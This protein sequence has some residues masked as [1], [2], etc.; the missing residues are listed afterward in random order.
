MKKSLLLIYRNFTCSNIYSLC[1]LLVF[2]YS[3]F[4]IK[5]NRIKRIDSKY[6]FKFIFQEL[7]LG[8]SIVSKLIYCSIWGGWLVRCFSVT[9]RLSDRWKEVC[10]TMLLLCDKMLSLRSTI[11][12]PRWPHNIH[13]VRACNQRQRRMQIREIRLLCK[14]ERV[15][16]QQR[17]GRGYFAKSI[18]AADKR[19]SCNIAYDLIINVNKWPKI[20]R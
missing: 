11:A 4:G 3:C 17:R 14:A 8:L 6:F 15:R 13:R 5:E 19:K 12:S 20:I 18:D 1:L 2:W 7:C 9:R 16:W 10:Q